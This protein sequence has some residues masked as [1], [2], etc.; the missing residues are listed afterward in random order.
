[1]KKLFIAF[2]LLT[3]AV[4]AGAQTRRR[5]VEPPMKPP[6]ENAFWILLVETPAQARADMAAAEP[7]MSLVV[8]PFSDTDYFVFRRVVADFV[9]IPILDDY[10]Y[11]LFS[12]WSVA[13]ARR[14]SIAAELHPKLFE[15]P[16]GAFALVYS[17]S[18]S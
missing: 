4:S 10:T 1:M 6:A 13:S 15:M 14:S 7:S 16:D 8:Y 5:T 18:D 3:I 17:R 2:L 9:A 11:E 12:S